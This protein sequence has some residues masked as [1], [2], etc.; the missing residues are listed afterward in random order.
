ML[1]PELKRDI[2]KLWDKFWSGGIANPLTAIEQIAYL[3]FM[4]RV[5][6]ADDA[7]AESARKEK[8]RPK[9]IFSGKSDMR[10]WSNFSKLSGPEMLALVQKEVFPFI[11]EMGD[12][13][14]RDAVFVIPSPTMHR[15]ISATASS[16]W[17]G[18]T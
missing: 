9:S 1:A 4:K 2:K 3:I 10:R 5:E 14:M 18:L 12:E 17:H 13:R 6:E 7:E 11:V 16:G 15:S 8:R